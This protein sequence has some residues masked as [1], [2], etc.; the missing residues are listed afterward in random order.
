MGPQ[1]SRQGSLSRK[2]VRRDRA[3]LP[4]NNPPLI[5]ALVNHQLSGVAWASGSLTNL[6]SSTTRWFD[7]GITQ[8]LTIAKGAWQWNFL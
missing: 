7:G 5:V 8:E 2:L 3:N 1:N 4:A 6:I